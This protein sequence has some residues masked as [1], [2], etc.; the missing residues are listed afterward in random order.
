MARWATAS[1]PEERLA[2]HQMLP[3][4]VVEDTVNLLESIAQNLRRM[5]GQ[6][7]LPD[8]LLRGL[9]ARQRLLIIVDA[10]SERDPATQ[11]HIETLYDHG[12]PVNAPRDHLSPRTRPEGH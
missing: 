8:D 2:P 1:Q 7:E 12:W 6:E 4:I 5:L 9:L 3:V 11:H 10:L